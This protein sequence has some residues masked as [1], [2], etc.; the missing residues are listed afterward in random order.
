MVQV[1]SLSNGAPWGGVC[2][3]SGD[4]KYIEISRKD[5]GERSGSF[6]NLAYPPGRELYDLNLDSA[7]E[8][9]LIE[10]ESG[11]ADTMRRTLR[12]ALRQAQDPV[13]SGTE[14]RD[15]SL[16]TDLTRQLQA[17]GYLD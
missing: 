11:V 13:A 5:G 14:E 2:L 7:E 15:A 12:D 1:A 17:L 4:Y 6:S 3:L 8:D 10:T 16:G 9:N